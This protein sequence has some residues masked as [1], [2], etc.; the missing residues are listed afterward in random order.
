MGAETGNTIVS[1]RGNALKAGQPSGTGGTPPAPAGSAC[2]GR[3]DGRA[4]AGP[5]GSPAG[6]TEVCAPLGRGGRHRAALSSSPPEGA[7][8]PPGH[9]GPLWLCAGRERL[10]APREA[11]G[12]GA[13]C[14]TW[15]CAALPRGSASGA[16]PA[17]PRFP[18]RTSRGGC[19]GGG[20]TG[21]ALP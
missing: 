4:P 19:G 3:G 1:R 5:L 10:G 9:R 12:R 6:C 14:A 15:P 11:A 16:C 8:G 2:R 17:A 7:G 21:P 13:S 18:R 20:S